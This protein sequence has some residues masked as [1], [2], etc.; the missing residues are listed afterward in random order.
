DMGNRNEAISAFRRAIEL[1]PDRAG[2]R[3]LVKSM[4][5]RSGFEEGRSVWEE[6]LKHRPTDHDRWYGYA[7]LCAFLEH[8]DLYRRACQDLLEQF[9]GDADHWTVAERNSLACLLLPP[10]K[11]QLERVVALVARTTAQ[12]RKYPHPDNGYIQFIRGLA[13]YRQ[14]RI[15]L[16]MPLLREAAA[17][18]PNR[19]GPRL[20]LAMAQFRNGSAKEAR[21]SLAE[22]VS[23]FNWR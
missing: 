20:V 18:I 11:A 19:P 14:E 4:T 6:L 10:D 5:T 7:H 13:E 23:V 8:D 17:V 21:Q 2:A 9:Q 1:N 15:E 12:E 16:A 22:A 3:D